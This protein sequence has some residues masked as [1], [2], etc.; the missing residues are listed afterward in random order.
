MK[1]TNEPSFVKQHKKVHNRNKAS[2]N[3]LTN[4]K[5]NNVQYWMKTNKQNVAFTMN[6]LNQIFVPY[7]NSINTKKYNNLNL[8]FRYFMYTPVPQ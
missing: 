8:N 1:P 7:L 4:Y 2:A 3:V 5:E 6:I